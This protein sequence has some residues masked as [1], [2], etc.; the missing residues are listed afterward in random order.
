MEIRLYTKNDELQLFN[1]MKEEGPEWECYFNTNA[2]E[3]Y[4]EALAN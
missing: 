2:V 4:K 3:K 1:M